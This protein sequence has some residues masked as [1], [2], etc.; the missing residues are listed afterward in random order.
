MNKDIIEYE[1]QNEKLTLTKDEVKKY[2]STDVNVSEK[3]VYMFMRLCQ[4]QKLNPFIKEA[5]LIKYGSSPANLVVGKETFLKRAEASPDFDGYDVSDNADTVEKLAVTCTVHRKS[6]AHPISVTVDYSEYVGT[7]ATGNITKI[8]KN[9]PRTMLRKVAIVQ[10]LR[11]AFPSAL[12]GLY[13]TTELDQRTAPVIE[14]KAETT[15]PPQVKK[16][17]LVDKDEIKKP[18]KERDFVAEFSEEDK[19]E[20]E[21]AKEEK[22]TTEPMISAGQVTAFKT[23]I[24]DKVS[25]EDYRQFMKDTFG[26]KSC[27]EFTFE[28]AKNAIE[29]VMKMSS[30][31]SEP[32]PEPAEVQ[33]KKVEIDVRDWTVKEIKQ[34]IW[35]IARKWD[36]QKGEVVDV[37]EIITKKLIDDF[38]KVDWVTIYKKF[39]SGEAQNLLMTG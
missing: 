5:Y 10:A 15:P 18:E 7:T 28:T 4:A 36:W 29:R 20:P 3:E 34:S 22:P 21:P 13:E 25:K 23:L 8:W 26:V 27:K 19:P 33:N 35:D 31:K 39:E 38:Y 2:I 1:W 11:E 12:G 17:E 16:R 9:K 24:A 30:Y 6:Q 14:T 37:A 32:A